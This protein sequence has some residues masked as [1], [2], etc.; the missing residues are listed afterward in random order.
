M[1]VQFYKQADLVIQPSLVEGFGLT[2]LEAMH[3]GVPVIASNTGAL[4]EVVGDV[5]ALF[6][7]S[8]VPPAIAA[9]IA[10]I[11]SAPALARSLVEQGIE[12]RLPG[13]FVGRTARLAVDALKALG[14]MPPCA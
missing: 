2:A 3:C 13:I 11:L 12:T 14:G 6:D 4:P 5:R 10:E 1:L 7:P 8:K 9:R